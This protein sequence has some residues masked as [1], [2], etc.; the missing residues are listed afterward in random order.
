[1]SADANTIRRTKILSRGAE[2]VKEA[3]ESRAD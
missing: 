2:M 3:T 1:M